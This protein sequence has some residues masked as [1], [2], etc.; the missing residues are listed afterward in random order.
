M[1]ERVVEAYR[2]YYGDVKQQF[3]SFRGEVFQWNYLDYLKENALLLWMQRYEGQLYDI[4]DT[5][6]LLKIEY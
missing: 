2:G 4:E 5:L 3:T 1:F 6:K